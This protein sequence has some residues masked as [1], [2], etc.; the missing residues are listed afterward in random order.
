[1]LLDRTALESEEVMT[2][3]LPA[4]VRWVQE[5]DDSVHLQRSL[6]KAREVFHSLFPSLPFFAPKKPRH[7]EV[8][9]EEVKG[10]GDAGEGGAGER[11]NNEDDDE[12]TRFYQEALR[13]L[14]PVQQSVS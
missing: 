8:D 13:S 9:G 4:G 1:M 10:E 2:S 14:A 7:S 12:E 3:S 6:T 11:S 5:S